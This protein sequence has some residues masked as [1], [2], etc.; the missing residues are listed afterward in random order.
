MNH[1]LLWPTIHPLRTTS[2]WTLALALA[3]ICVMGEAR[4]ETRTVKAGN[5]TLKIPADWEQLKT[6]SQF[7]LAEFK[8]PSSQAGEEAAELVVYYFGGGPT[9]GV[10][11]N[12]QRWVDQFREQGRQVELTQGKAELGEYV[13]ANIS[14]TWKKPDGPPFAQKSI[15]KPGSRVIGVVLMIPRGQ[16]K[17]YFFLKLAGPD[18]LVQAQADALR[19]ALA[20]ERAT[21]KPYPLDAAK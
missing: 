20:A 9:G 19:S 10:A 13:L 18:A 11:A 3:T 6:E 12:V 15:D 8:I 21:E 2:H 16:E 17:E 1:R 14:G 7:R 5:L 4:G